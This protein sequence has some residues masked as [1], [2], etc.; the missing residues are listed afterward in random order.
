MDVKQPISYEEQVQYI[1]KK[2]FLIEDE[3]KS[4]QFLKKANYYRLS[5]FFLPFK[6]TNG[7]YFKNIPFQ[8]VQRIYEFDSRI[9][10]LIFWTIE[11][12]EF[13]LRTQMSYYSARMYGALGYLKSEHFSERHN[14]QKYQEKLQECVSENERTLVVKHHN[15][16][17][18]GKFPIWVIIEFFSMGMLSYFYNDMKAAD[19]KKLAKEM[20]GTSAVCLMSWLRCLTDLRNRCAHYARLYYWSFPAMPKVPK[21][22]EFKA[23]RKLFTQII[24]LRWLFPDKEKWNTGVLTEL[25]A[26]IEA[27][28]Q[29]ISLNHI[30][31]PTEWEALLIK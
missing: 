26:L 29:D 2:G 19:R 25:K 13:Y 31:F 22:D 28:E 6:K 18:D 30:G 9:R 27:Y 10:A 16:H 21:S 17:Y 4:L 3:E 1:E 14:Q 7:T 24:M 20:Y 15:E 8:R 23:D 12:I 5:A 11:E